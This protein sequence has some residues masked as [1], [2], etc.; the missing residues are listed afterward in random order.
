M[1]PHNSKTHYQFFMSISLK[2]MY[3]NYFEKRRWS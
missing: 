2:I 1:N 3:Y